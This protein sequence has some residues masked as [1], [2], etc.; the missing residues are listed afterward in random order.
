MSDFG[1]KTSDLGVSIGTNFEQ[2]ENLFFKPEISTAYEKLETTTAASASL[3]KQ[4]GDYFDTYLNYQ[5]D[6][7]MR[8]KRYRPD[9]GFRST[10]YQELPLISE[11]YEIV[12]SFDSARYKKLS[13][14]LTKISLYGKAVNTLND[15]DVRISK[16]L[17][18]PA[19]KLRGFEAGKVGPVQN[20]DFVGGNYVSSVNFSSTLPGLLP[21]FQ[22]TDISF[23]IDVANVWGVDYDSSMDTGNKI[24]SATGVALDILTP[25]GPLTFSLTQPITKTS[26]DKTESF[27]FNLGTTF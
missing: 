23:F 14:V 7:D 15:E 27:R 2:Y 19:N 4:E 17:F 21:A 18:M 10:F 24:R 6:Y 3:K 1:Y 12:N 26:T 8:N 9:E 25:V 13:N 11:N 20:G 5:L 16:R 22:S